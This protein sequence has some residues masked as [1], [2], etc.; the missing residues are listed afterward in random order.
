MP[1]NNSPDRPRRLV[2]RVRVVMAERDI[3]TITRLAELLSERGVSISIAQLGRLVDGKTKLWN[4]EVLE[5]LMAVLDCELS[6]LV[7]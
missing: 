7:R 3:R 6:D 5:G 1:S 4:Q 2:W